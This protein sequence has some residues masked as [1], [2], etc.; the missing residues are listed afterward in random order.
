M[1]RGDR[2]LAPPIGTHCHTCPLFVY[3]CLVQMDARDLSQHYPT[4]R[5]PVCECVWECVWECVCV[6]GSV[7]VCVWECVWEYM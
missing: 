6:C 4:P 5:K 3:L 1:E 7:C 2:E